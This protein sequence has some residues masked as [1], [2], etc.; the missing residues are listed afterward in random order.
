MS[1]IRDIA[2]MCHVSV[3]TVSNVLNHKQGASK[4]TIKLV[5]EAAQQLNYRPNYLAKSLAQHVTKSLGIIT[6]D[7]TT[8]TTPEIVDG[9]NEFCEK[10]QYQMVLGNMRLYKKYSDTYYFK[11]FYKDQIDEEL[12]VMRAKQVMGVI[13]VGENE[14]MLNLL[15][16]DP[17]LPMVIAYGMTN[18]NR[19]PYVIVNEEQG[20][21]EAMECL[22]SKG[23]TQIG[24]IAGPQSSY[25]MR[26]RLKGFQKALY[27]K[28]IFYNPENI[29]YG[30]WERQ[31]GYDG[32]RELIGRGINAIFTLNDMMAGGVYKYVEEQGLKVGTDI[33]LVGFDNREFSTWFEP[34]LTTMRLPLHDIG[35][36]AAKV[37][38]DMLENREV[39]KSYQIACSLIERGSIAQAISE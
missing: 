28:R 2:K 21:Y 24:V 10:N 27:E 1:G 14:R 36:H 35:Y 9:I 31:S 11:D 19:I 5:R 34:K 20:A 15:P 38:V 4:E 12:E 29:Y 13:Y 3:S 30:D 16:S 6:E 8:F 18:N 17:P 33:S 23:H 7:L 25:S 37:M 22:L 39:E 26:A 32:A